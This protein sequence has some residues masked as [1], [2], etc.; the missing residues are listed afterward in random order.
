VPVPAKYR[1]FAVCRK[2][3]ILPN[4]RSRTGV[5]RE[6]LAGSATQG[7]SHMNAHHYVEWLTAIFAL[8]AAAAWIFSATAKVKAE[9]Q[10]GLDAA[11]IGG[12][13]H[14]TH[15]GITYDLH[16]TLRRQSK[17]NAYAA[18]LAACAAVSQAA[19]AWAAN[20][21]IPS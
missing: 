10:S 18:S 8:L 21:P 19:S 6:A 11:V 9:H 1:L 12:W 13:V 3:Q 16:K 5:A 2:T 7:E 15:R 20:A 4:A 17:W 14:F